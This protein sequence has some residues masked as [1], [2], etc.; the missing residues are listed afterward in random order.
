MPVYIVARGP[1]YIR[2]GIDDVGDIIEIFEGPGAPSGPGY[3]LSD[4][5]EISVLSKNDVTNMLNSRKPETLYDEKEDKEYWHDTQDTGNWYE[6]KLKPKYGLNIA[7]FTLQDKATLANSASTSVE[8]MN[9]LAKTQSNI[10]KYSAN[11]TTLKP[12]E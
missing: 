7:D 2:E 4:I 12:N 1:K 10:A 9:I 8:Q 3:A 6:I 5:V 11:K